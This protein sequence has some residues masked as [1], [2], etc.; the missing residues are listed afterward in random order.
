[1]VGTLI[2]ITANN[3]KRISS[4]FSIFKCMWSSLSSH[5][6]D[7]TLGFS[8]F[9]A[10]SMVFNILGEVPV[11]VDTLGDAVGGAVGKLRDGYSN[12]VSIFQVYQGGVIIDYYKD[13][14]RRWKQ[15]EKE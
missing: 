11:L 13:A 8:I 6:S 9:I 3:D 1:M 10:L 14:Q 7:C 2:L 5:S 4:H 12:A 15:I